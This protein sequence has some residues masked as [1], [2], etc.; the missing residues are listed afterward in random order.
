MNPGRLG[1]STLVCS[2]PHPPSTQN[3]GKA[4]MRAAML[5]HAQLVQRC[6]IFTASV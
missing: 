4:M 6:E 1:G 2:H 3:K 5:T